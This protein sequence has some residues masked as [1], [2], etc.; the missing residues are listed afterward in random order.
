METR[1]AYASPGTAKGCDT[2]CHAASARQVRAK[3]ASV[4]ARPS[5]LTSVGGSTNVREPQT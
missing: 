5:W 1:T 2:L 3:E 4:M